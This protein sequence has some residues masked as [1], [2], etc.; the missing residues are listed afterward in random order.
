[1]TGGQVDDGDVEVGQLGEVRVTLS[2]QLVDL[3]G[4]E[5]RADDRHRHLEA[6]WIDQLERVP[7]EAG[8]M[9]HRPGVELREP[10]V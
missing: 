4:R 1:V 10:V 8:R 9:R 5:R 3:L 6:A 2:R 7:G